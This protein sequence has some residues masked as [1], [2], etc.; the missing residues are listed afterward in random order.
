MHPSQLCKRKQLLLWI[1]KQPFTSYMIKFS[2]K[3]MVRLVNYEIDG[4]FIYFFTIYLYF[5]PVNVL[6]NK[7]NKTH[8]EACYE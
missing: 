4:L 2:E 1:Y 6:A 7:T 8:L 5:F 3:H